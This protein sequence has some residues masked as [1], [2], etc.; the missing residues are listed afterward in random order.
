MFQVAEV[1]T[2]SLGKYVP[3]KETVQGFK[4]ILAGLYTLLI[5]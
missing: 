5:P 4:K 3:L 1:F 2:G